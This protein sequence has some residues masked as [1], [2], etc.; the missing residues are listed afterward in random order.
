[1]PEVRTQA[2]THDSEFI[3]RFVVF[4]V[5]EDYDDDDDVVVHV[6]DAVVV[7]DDDVFGDDVFGVDVV[8]DV[9][10]VKLYYCSCCRWC[11]WYLL[12]K[13]RNYFE[14]ERL[15]SHKQDLR[16]HISSIKPCWT[17][18]EAN[19]SLIANKNKSTLNISIRWSCAF[20][21]FNMFQGFGCNKWFSCHRED[22]ELGQNHFSNLIVHNGYFETRYELVNHR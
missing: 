12:T 7:D 1:M 5:L 15:R 3:L 2:L 8:A 10:G 22:D 19:I 21:S 6:I 4:H 13:P 20:T 16:F 18:L 14:K 9:V 11:V 17:T